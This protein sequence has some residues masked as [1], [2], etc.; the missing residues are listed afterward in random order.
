MARRI[1]FLDGTHEDILQPDFPGNDIAQII[2]ERLGDDFAS[3][4]DSYFLGQ[5]FNDKGDNYEDIAD[6]YYQMLH[7]VA[8]E[9]EALIDKFQTGERVDRRNLFRTLTRIHENI[10]NNL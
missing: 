1:Y 10:I 8:D 3:F 6:E 7:G 4:C 2:R 9:I 5:K